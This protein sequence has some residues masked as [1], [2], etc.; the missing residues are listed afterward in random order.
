MAN[1]QYA[2]IIQYSAFWNKDLVILVY[3][4]CC[5][6]IILEIQ[7]WFYM[8]GRVE[9]SADTVR[10]DA[11]TSTIHRKLSVRCRNG[12]RIPFT[13]HKLLELRDA[14]YARDSNGRVNDIW[15]LS[16]QELA[17]VGNR[18]F[19]KISIMLID[20]HFYFKNISFSFSKKLEYLKAKM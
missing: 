15:P 12:A 9:N 11:T 7:Y 2:N 17:R 16:L 5:W 14:D 18:E 20:I 1:H 6:W 4:S 13:N 10:T 19:S 3:L 8:K